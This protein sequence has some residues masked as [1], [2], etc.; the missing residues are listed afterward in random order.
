[1][2]IAF[3]STW[4][5][6]GTWLPGDDR[7]WFDPGAGVRDPDHMRRQIASLIM[8]ENA[9]VLDSEQRSLVESVIL[10]H[11]SIPNWELHAVSCR[12]NHAHVVVSAS[13]RAI[14]VPREQ[15]K[16]WATRRLKE[17]ELL[18][19]PT[20]SV[21]MHWWAERGWDVYIDTERD[22]RE[23]VDYVAE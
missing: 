21:R 23:V 11:C 16:L 22:L 10:K 5:T 18:R 13:E 20:R 1:M 6:Y 2:A 8:S 9:V 3:F 4:T 17:L 15:F 7:G 14:A 19:D 12:S